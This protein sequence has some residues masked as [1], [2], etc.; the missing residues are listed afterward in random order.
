MN[1]YKEQEALTDIGR[2]L[3]YSLAGRYTLEDG[4]V[5][6]LDLGFSE[7]E[8][9]PESIG[10]LQSL[11]KLILRNNKFKSLPACI[12]EIKG[13]VWLDLWG[14]Q[15][16]ELPDSLANLTSLIFLDIAGNKITRLSYDFANLKIRRLHV[17]LSVIESSSSVIDA[18]LEKGARVFA[19]QE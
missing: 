10:R 6:E 16:E 15:L 8:N 17:G 18:L 5:V 1:E 19:N 2:E 12:S 13:L 7:L 9:L 3:G 4:K 14:N 11:K